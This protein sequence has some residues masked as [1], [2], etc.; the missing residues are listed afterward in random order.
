M[1]SLFTFS[2]NMQKMETY[3]NTF[4][5]ITYRIISCWNSSTKLVYP[6]NTSMI[7]KFFIVILNLRTF[8]SEMIK[9][10]D[11][12]ISAGLVNTQWVNLEQ[13]FAGLM[14][15]WLQKF[16]PDKHKPKPLTFGLLGYCFTNYF[17]KLLLL[18]S[19]K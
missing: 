7:N 3:L 4:V 6:F 5:K 1:K 12:V 10:L 17:I 13:V 15:I 14:S 18:G 11:C 16:S 8:L 19:K 2:W 9:N